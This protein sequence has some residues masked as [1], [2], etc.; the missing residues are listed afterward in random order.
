M[1]DFI[2]YYSK[3]IEEYPDT[4]LLPKPMRMKIKYEKNKHITL[5]EL[6]ELKR[7]FHLICQL[8][9][10]AM[11]LYKIT[12]GCLEVTWLV[13]TELGEC[14]KKELRREKIH[15]SEKEVQQ[16]ILSVTVGDYCVYNRVSFN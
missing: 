9:D 5:M 13:T 14:L 10:F 16:Q 7:S 11:I 15:H 8:P 4:N 3:S 2:P 1:A 6:D 12:E